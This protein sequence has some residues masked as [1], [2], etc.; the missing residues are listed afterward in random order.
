MLNKSVLT[1][2]MLA[3]TASAWAQKV[4]IKDPWVRATVPSQMATGAFM[5]LTADKPMRLVS[6][7][8]SVA[9][10]VEIHE[11]AMVNDVMK[12]RKIDGLA[13]PAGKATELKP[14]GYHVMFMDLKQQMK[15]GESVS[16]TLVFEDADKKRIEQTVS[17]PIK[18]MVPTKM[19]HGQMGG[20]HKH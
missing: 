4:E 5:N 9:G 15:E 3:V 13:L 12:M 20:E 1:L 14:G 7:K 11:M 16:L 2:A 18:A 6:A 17:A 10:V 19:G 8:S